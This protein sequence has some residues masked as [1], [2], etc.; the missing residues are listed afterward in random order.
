MRPGW[1]KRFGN[2]FGEKNWNERRSIAEQGIYVTTH[3]FM[4]TPITDNWQQYVDKKDTKEAIGAM[5]LMKNI[6][7]DYARFLTNIKIHWHT[8]S[9]TD[10]AAVKRTFLEYAS[11]VGT[12]ALSAIAMGFA[13]DDDDGK[14]DDD[15]S[16]PMLMLLYQ[17]DRTAVELTTYVP[18]AV[19]PPTG[20]LDGYV[21][22][23]WFNEAKKL[24]KSPTA[25]FS[26]MESIIKLSKEILYYPFADEDETVYQGGTY[27]GFS[28]AYIQGIKLTPGANKA[29]TMYFLRQSHNVYKLF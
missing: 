5:T 9:E 24:F 17:L 14:V 16:Y 11:F 27:H 29:L 7:T 6:V 21:G 8:L 20:V 25:T 23:G 18:L 26:T 13:D 22:G 4:T 10:K 2:R 28:K 1:N 3:R 15:V 12:M 19:V